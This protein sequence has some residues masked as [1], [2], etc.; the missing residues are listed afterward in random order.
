MNKGSY[1]FFFIS[2]AFALGI[3]FAI[4]YFSFHYVYNITRKEII[5]SRI[6][7]NKQE[8]IHMARL[9]AEQ[10]K[11]GSSKKQVISEFQKSIQYTPIDKGFECMFNQN[12][13]QLCHPDPD[14]IGQIIDSTNSV[15]SLMNNERHKE[16]FENVL[17]TG[18]PGGGVRSFL[19][20]KFTEVIYVAPVEGSDLMVAVHANLIYIENQLKDFHEKLL[21]VF[22]ISGLL[23]TLIVFVFIRFLFLNMQQRFKLLTEK[24][25]NISKNI[26]E[27]QKAIAT[28]ETYPGEQNKKPQSRLLVQQGNKLVPLLINELAY[29]YIEYK[30]TY[31]INTKGESFTSNLSLEEVYEQLNPEEFFRA[32]RQFIISI[33]SIDKVERYGNNQLRVKV[34]PPLNKDIIISKL[35][36]AAFKK[37]L[38]EN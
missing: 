13:V 1:F 14:K 9:L 16:N 12:G 15:I 24:E 27:S 18:K 10:L 38:G 11:E 22:L 7:A 36:I 28:K 35:K 33:R 26:R 20:K 3:T 29:A 21:S 37:W 6:E 4:G 31:L 25:S 30:L 23:T 32:N 5:D 34:T 2:L 8:A 19:Q 17:K